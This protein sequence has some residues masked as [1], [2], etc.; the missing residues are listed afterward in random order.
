MNYYNLPEFISYA[1]LVGIALALIREHKKQVYLRY[2]LAGWIIILMHA[3]VYMLIIPDFIANL[4][5][6]RFAN[7]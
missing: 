5:G 1:I 2:W 3:G 7:H 4:T 6:M